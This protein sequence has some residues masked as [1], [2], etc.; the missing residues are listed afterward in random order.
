MKFIV[1]LSLL[2]AVASAAPKRLVVPVKDAHVGKSRI[3]S[4]SP[5][6]PGQ[7]P[8]QVLD[9][10]ELILGT[11]YCGGALISS[12]WVLT[13]AHCA[14]G[15]YSHTVTLGTIYFNGDD[16]NAVVVHT[17][18]HILHEN[19]D[20]LYLWNDVALVDFVSD[21]QFTDYIQPISLGSRVVESNAPVWVSGWGKTSDPSATVSPILNFVNLN[22]ISNE[23]CT[24]AYGGIVVDGTLCCRGNPEHSTCNGDSG[25]PLFEYDSEEKPHHIGVVSFVHMAGC[26]SGYPSGYTRTSSYISWIESYTGPL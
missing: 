5:A 20:S 19:Y 24:I 4:G 22:T 11:S 26:D 2:L 10:Y 16:P 3:I 23:D 14:A 21:V 8:F 1:A 17:T 15:A 25:G 18:S 6:D 13:A 12:R 7:F 9:A